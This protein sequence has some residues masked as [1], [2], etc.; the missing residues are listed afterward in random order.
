M[1]R[2]VSG[3]VRRTT[4]VA[5]VASDTVDALVSALQHRHIST[6]ILPADISCGVMGPNRLGLRSSR[7]RRPETGDLEAV[8]AG[9]GPANQPSSS[10]GATPPVSPA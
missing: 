9:C 2:T 4:D 7:P 5:R 6:L 1:A 10:S 8:E 3:W